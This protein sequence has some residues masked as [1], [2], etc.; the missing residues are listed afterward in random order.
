MIASRWT[1]TWRTTGGVCSQLVLSSGSPAGNGI[2]VAT[3][4]PLCVTPLDVLSAAKR[5]LSGQ[6]LAQRP[7][8]VPARLLLS[9]QLARGVGV[10][11][12]LVVASYEQRDGAE[13]REEDGIREP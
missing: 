12:G 6:Q 11:P 9:G 10:S 7:C 3:V 4:P 5:H 1:T 8:L 13:L 2:E